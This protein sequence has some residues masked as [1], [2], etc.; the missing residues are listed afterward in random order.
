MLKLNLYPNPKKHVYTKISNPVRKTAYLFALCATH[1][2][3][4][5][6]KKRLGGVLD[7]LGGL[8]YHINKIRIYEKRACRLVTDLNELSKNKEPFNLPALSRRT[9]HHPAVHEAVAYIGRLGQLDYFFESDWFSEG[10][11]ETKLASGI[12]SILAPM[13]LRNKHSAHRQ[14]DYP[15]KDDSLSLGLNEY[16]LKH[17]LVGFNPE[18]DHVNIQYSFPTIQRH[19]LL[20]K[21]RPSPVKE[22]EHFGDNNNLVI[23]TPTKVHQKILNEG[24]SLLQHFFDFQP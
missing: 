1:P 20:K 21:Y 16:G 13:P 22:I 19:S 18:P 3:Y 2:L 7:I 8:E 10:I 12:P 11:S 24:I 14:Q 5:K 6:H 15:W 4:L 17:G 23:F 9:N